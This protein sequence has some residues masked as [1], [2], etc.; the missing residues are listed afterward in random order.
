VEKEDVMYRIKL[1]DHD[2]DDYYYNNS[3]IL[4]YAERGNIKTTFNSVCFGIHGKAVGTVLLGGGG[5]ID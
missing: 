1:V 4:L 5:E 3:S 2:D